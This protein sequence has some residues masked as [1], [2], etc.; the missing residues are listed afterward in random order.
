MLAVGGKVL[1]IGLSLS[2]IGHAL[3]VFHRHRHASGVQ[4]GP[5][6]S[7][8]N[9]PYHDTDL[10]L[11]KYPDRLECVVGTNWTE[12]FDF[13]AWATE[14]FGA[15]TSF[16]LPVDA[17]GVYLLARGSNQLGHLS[18]V[19]STKVSNVADVNIRV[20]YRSEEAL[21]LASVCL[22]KSPRN[23]Y[24][25]GIFTPERRRWSDKEYLS[26]TVE[27][28]LPAGKGGG[29]LNIK[30]LQTELPNYSQVVADLSKT[31]SFDLISLQSTSGHITVE[32]VT[33]AAGSF[34]STNGG[35]T[36]SVSAE[37]SLEVETT[38]GAI[39]GSFSG[40][41]VVLET[42]NGA[43]QANVTLMNQLD[44]YTSKLVMHTSNGYGH[45]YFTESHGFI[46]FVGMLSRKLHLSRIR[47][48]AGSST[49]T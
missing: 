36:G 22:T 2:I 1:V 6:A 18:I 46:Q 20:A 34:K 45:C 41:L 47:L 24:G 44:N 35:I 14:P 31:A 9:Q 37:E 8:L 40:A 17:D 26:F 19:Q 11:P 7:P 38:N 49:S 48:P 13:L 4:F 43:I 39:V 5:I 33:S 15:E 32:S 29:S 28:T 3:G 16:S 12:Y 42:S 21:D 27:L 10:P 23:E 30:K 25:I